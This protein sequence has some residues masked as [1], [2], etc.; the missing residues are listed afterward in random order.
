MKK[1]NVECQKDIFC[2]VNVPTNGGGK[3][4]FER[5][6]LPVIECPDEVKKGEYFTIN[7]EVGRDVPHPNEP[8]HFIQFI[9]LYSGDTYL[10]R[11]DLTGERTSPKMSASVSLDH[12]HGEIRAF[13]RCNLHGVWE[14]RKPIRVI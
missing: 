2:G 12:D 13:E 11:M 10:A 1:G 5:T 3:T 14:S 4:D 7:V 9:E 8:G 6:H